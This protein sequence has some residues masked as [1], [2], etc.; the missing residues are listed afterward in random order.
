MKVYLDHAATTPLD[1]RVL[2][3]MLPCFTQNFGNPDSPHSFGRA[4]A[5]YVDEARD[6]LAKELGA[7]PNEI[8]FT[9]GGSESDNWAL[10]GVMH[11]SKARKE[12]LVSAIEH[13]AALNTAAELQKEGYT[14]RIVP[15]LPDGKIDMAALRSLLSENT[16]LVAVMTANNEIGTVEPIRQIADAAHSVGAYMMTDAVQAVGSLP[17]NVQSLHADLLTLSAHKFYGPK[18]VG[19]L[20]VRRGVPI[21]KIISGGH[22]ERAMRG[23]TTNVPAVVGMAEALRLANAHTDENAKKISALRN[24]FVRRVLTEIPDVRYNG[25]ACDRL[26]GNAHFTF[27]GVIGEALLFALDIQGIAASAGSACSSGSLEPSHVLK[28]IGLSETAAKSSVRFSFGK[29]NTE[30]EMHYTADTLKNL[31]AKMRK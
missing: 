18:G 16:A 22:Q 6:T 10:R 23:G 21:G 17:V 7:K 1:E 4:A 15:V 20:Y 29:N 2:Q 11:A 13:P 31:V 12:L 27:D 9:S 30:E 28:A 5:V 19:A 8:F 24:A 3:K 14:V 25:D 26:P